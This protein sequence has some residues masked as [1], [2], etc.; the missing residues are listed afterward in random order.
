MTLAGGAIG[1]PSRSRTRPTSRRTTSIFAVSIFLRQRGS[2]V[3]GSIPY[4]RQALARDS[5]YA[6][7]WSEVGEAYCVL[8]LYSPVPVDSSL[9]LGRAAIA[10]AHTLDPIDANAFAAEGFCD[11]LASQFREADAAIRRA[12]WPRFEQRH[13]QSSS[14]VALSVDGSHRRCSGRRAARAARFDPMSARPRGSPRKSCSSP[15]ATTR[16][17][18]SRAARSSSTRAPPPGRLMYAL[19][20]ASVGQDGRGA[21][22]AG[23]RLLHHAANAAVDGLSARGDRRPYGRSQPHSSA[24]DAARTQFIREFGRGVGVPRRRA[25]RRAPSTR[26]SVPRGHMSRSGS[27]CRSACPH[28]TPCGTAPASRR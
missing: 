28:T 23:R 17:S 3:M 11:M 18:C 21:Q 24:R 6:R 16:A 27:P 4:F 22:A 7:A 25:T 13:R 15:S 9:P 19:D 12:R 10:K 1:R 26:S 2:G 5:T 8:P 14:L 20:P